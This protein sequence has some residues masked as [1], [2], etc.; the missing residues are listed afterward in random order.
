M[1][2]ALFAAF[3]I[4]LLGSAHCLGMC[5]GI[6]GALALRLPQAV[7]GST[8]RLLPY[9]L[10]YNLGRIASYACAGALAGLIGAQL[11]HGLAAAQAELAGRVLSSVFLIALGLYIAGWTRLLAPLERAGAWFWR[12]IEPLGRRLLP[13]SSPGQALALGVVWGWLPCGLVYGA[14]ALALTAGGILQ[15]AALMAAFGLGTLPM[16]LT[17]GAAAGLLRRLSFAPALR[18][19]MG[20]AVLIFGVARLVLSGLHEQV[21]AGMHA[22][23]YVPLG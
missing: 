14:L 7:Q 16:L 19:A 17:M 8:T 22:L 4:G 3:L 11:L 12:W 9:A 10:C 2:L 23:N 18:R 6:V 5:G 1:D 13:V 20:A 15:G 21:V